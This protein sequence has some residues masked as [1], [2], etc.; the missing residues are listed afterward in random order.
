MGVQADHMLVSRTLISGV[1]FFTCWSL[2]AYAVPITLKL[3]PGLWEMTSQGENSGALP[4]PAEALARLPPDRRAKMEAALAASRARAAKPHVSRQCITAESLQRGI[5]LDEKRGRDCQERV[6]SSSS[7]DMDIQV[8]CK[9]PRLTSSGNVHFTAT[10]AERL[11]GTINM[12]ISDGA[13]NMTMRRVI[14]GRWIA[15]DCGGVKARQ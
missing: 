7:S 3:R 13:Q 4:M 10:G 12:K 5:D 9:G 6:I 15:A 8:E 11:N 2:A 14:E 1:A